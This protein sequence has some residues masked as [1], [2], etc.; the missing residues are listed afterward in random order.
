[1]SI[2]LS[3]GFSLRASIPLDKRFVYNTLTDL[4]NESITNL[5]TGLITY[6]IEENEAD[7]S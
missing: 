4:Q 1:M 6:V 5:Y 3:N 7:A 2:Q